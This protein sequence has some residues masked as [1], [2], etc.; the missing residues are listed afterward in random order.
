METSTVVTFNKNFRFALGGAGAVAGHAAIHRLVIDARFLNPEHVLGTIER[1]IVVIVAGFDFL[2]VSEPRHGDWLGARELDDQLQRFALFPVLVLQFSYE[3]RWDIAK[4]KEQD[5]AITQWRANAATGKFTEKS[6]PEK[7][8][9]CGG[10]GLLC[11]AN[12]MTPSG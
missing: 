3:H 2:V 1:E 7:L 11:E 4:E 12:L 6:D 5:L 9:P 8:M 10:L